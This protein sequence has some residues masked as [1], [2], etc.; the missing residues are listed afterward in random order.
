[1]TDF[2]HAYYLEARECLQ[3][4]SKQDLEQPETWANLLGAIAN[5]V[6]ASVPGEVYD[7]AMLSLVPSSPRKVQRRVKKALGGC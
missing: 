5:A 7:A 3:R 6:M 1:M 2:R 4:C